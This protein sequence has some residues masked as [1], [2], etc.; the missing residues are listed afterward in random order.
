[1]QWK[2]DDK[3][4]IYCLE[5]NEW[6][7]GKIMEIHNLDELSVEYVQSDGKKCVKKIQ[8]WDRGLLPAIYARVTI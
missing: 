3:V 2:K 5:L 8:R 6:N 7:S 1:M 4:K